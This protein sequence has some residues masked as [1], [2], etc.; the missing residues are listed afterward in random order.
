M[1]LSKFQFFLKFVIQ[2]SC[3]MRQDYQ[4]YAQNIQVLYVNGQKSIILDQPY[5]ID[6]T[7]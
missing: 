3:P 2:S 6:S 5:P 1:Y 4:Q 7:F